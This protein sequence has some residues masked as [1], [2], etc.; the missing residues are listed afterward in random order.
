MTEKRMMDK[1]LEQHVRNLGASD[2]KV[3]MKALDTVLKLTDQKK[4]EKFRKKY[5]AIL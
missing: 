1:E 3:R 4:E 5:E 2:D